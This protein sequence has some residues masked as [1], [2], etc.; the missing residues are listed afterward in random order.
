MLIDLLAQQRVT[1][2]QETTGQFWFAV[3]VIILFAAGSLILWYRTDFTGLPADQ[4]RTKGD[5]RQQRQA[6]SPLSVRIPATADVAEYW[7]AVSSVI[8]RVEGA[9]GD[10]S[11]GVED[12]TTTSKALAEAREE[13]SRAW[14]PVLSRLPKRARQAIEVG[15]L[16]AIFGATAVSTSAVVSLLERGSGMP[17]TLAVLERAVELTQT[18][19]STG[20]T[21]FPFAD[22][23]WAMTFAYSILAVQWIYTHWYVTATLVIVGGLLLAALEYQAS[24]EDRHALYDR[25]ETTLSVIGALVL[26]WLAGT[27]PAA[28]GAGLVAVGSVTGVAAIGSPV[29]TVAAAIGFLLA[30]ATA[31]VLFA[32]AVAGLLQDVLLAAGAG[33][34]FQ[35]SGR[36]RPRA[37]CRRLLS[38]TVGISSDGSSLPQPAGDREGDWALVGSILL[39]RALNVINGLLVVVLAAYVVVSVADGRLVRVLSALAS[40]PTDTKLAVSL[41]VVV[42]LAVLAV[43]ARA[44]WP[45]LKTAAIESFARQRV[46]I[47]ILGRGVP[48][49]GVV[50]GYVV[51]YQLFESIPLA[52]IAGIGVGVG[53]YALYVL[54]LKSQHQLSM[55][56]LDEPLPSETLVQ[57]YPPLS[58]TVDDADAPGGE[59]DERRYYAVINGTTHV[60]WPEREKFESDL[61][62]AVIECREKDGTPCSVS[63]WHARDA[64][65]YGR[66]DAD[67]TCQKV[68]EKIRKHT[69]QPLREAKGATKRADVLEDLEQFPDDRRQKRW[70]SWFEDGILRQVDD[71]LVLEYDPWKEDNRRRSS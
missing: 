58:V 46:R 54:V 13:V 33:L 71:L 9:S 60:L 11:P 48:T 21:A 22:M 27:I 16:I 66:I 24:G 7:P 64:F 2:P 26:V 28:L 49:V 42:P 44:A 43:Q 19:L 35:R 41:L 23:V 12:R 25:R 36:Y 63:T 20:L 6:L 69:V 37:V 5:L 14:T 68:D 10:S 34:R 39:R 31:L 45:D 51:A 70:E 30:F 59:R 1:V 4:Q 65:E 29:A 40:A 62:S 53:L 3:V 32:G 52:V 56:K 8:D 17:S 47:A 15:V 55:L 50:G 67:A 38:A 18:V 57:V 61:Q